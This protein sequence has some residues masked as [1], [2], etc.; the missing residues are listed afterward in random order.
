MKRIISAILACVLATPFAFADN[1]ET[2]DD[3]FFE[4]LKLGAITE[5]IRLAGIELE[6]QSTLA[7]ILSELEHSDRLVQNKML[8]SIQQI[9]EYEFIHM[10]KDGE[11]YS[12]K[13][14]YLGMADKIENHNEEYVLSDDDIDF[15][16]ARKNSADPSKIGGG[17]TGAFSR[18]QLAF[19]G[20]DGI[21]S[22]VTLPKISH[23]GIDL[24]I[25]DGAK[26]KEQPW[27]YYGFDLK[28][29][30][31]VEGGFSYQTGQQL[32]KPYIRSIKVKKQFQ[33]EPNM[34][35]YNDGDTL[36]DVKFYLKNV[37]EKVYSYFFVGSTPVVLTTETPFKKVDLSKMSVKHCTGIA[38]NFPF[39]G[40]NILSISRN[41]KWDNV[42]VSTND[43]DY[44]HSWSSD[45]EVRWNENNKIFGTVDCID[46]YIHQEKGY[47][48]IFRTF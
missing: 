26:D 4:E 39:N 11:V 24:V 18:K 16:E 35:F 29:G 6:K 28:H 12:S 48:S 36:R 5:E 8:E 13:D 37:N 21:I 15:K 2:I 41:Q 1:K 7:D 33:Y 43:T 44:Y 23:F 9:Y 19:N 42:R 47:T 22:D 34:Y 14:G 46:S 45:N 38:S 32:W 30:H 25:E 3:H 10:T 20:Y 31:A 27:V 40:W 17:K